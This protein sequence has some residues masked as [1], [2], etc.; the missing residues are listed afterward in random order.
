MNLVSRSY[1]GDLLKGRYSDPEKSEFTLTV[2]GTDPI[3]LG[4][5]DLKTTAK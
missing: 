2:I 5:I 4:T 3:D 1:S